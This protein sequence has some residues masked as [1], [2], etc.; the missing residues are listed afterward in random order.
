MRYVELF[1]G[2]GGT[3]CGLERAGWRC[4]GAADNSKAAIDTYSQNFSHP[5]HLMDLSLPIEAEV[6]EEWKRELEEGALVASSPLHRLL[7]RQLEAT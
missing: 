2:A 7:D 5:S 1:C 6:A 4:V 3:S